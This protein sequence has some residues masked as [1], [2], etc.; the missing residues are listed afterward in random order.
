MCEK[1]KVGFAGRSLL[2]VCMLLIV[3][4]IWAQEEAGSDEDAKF[5]TWKQEIEK[6]K[7]DS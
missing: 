1:M 4:P 6:K 2:V 3:S 7:T 5:I